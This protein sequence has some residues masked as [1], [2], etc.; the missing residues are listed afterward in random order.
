MNKAPSDVIKGFQQLF[1]AHK[2]LS[3]LIM[4]KNGLPE[5]K[6]ELVSLDA[7]HGLNGANDLP[8]VWLRRFLRAMRDEL[9]ELEE[10]IAWK[11]WKPTVKTDL[12]NVRVEIVDL[13]HFLLSA[14]MA[15][16]MTAED[17]ANIYYKKRELNFDRQ[18]TGFVEGDNEARGIGNLR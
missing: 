12:P 9:R 15:S 14:A 13:F 6:L 8:S 5:A 2:E 16:G 18:N 10:S 11:W 4:M 17:F 7:A 1:D 3:D